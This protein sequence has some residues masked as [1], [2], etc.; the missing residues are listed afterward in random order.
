MASATDINIHKY[1][2]S[3]Q[4]GD[5]ITIQQGGDDPERVVLLRRG[6]KNLRVQRSGGE[7]FLVGLEDVKLEGQ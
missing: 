7:A 6:R 2:K 1:L 5:N 3:K 4:L